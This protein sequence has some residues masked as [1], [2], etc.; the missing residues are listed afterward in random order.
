M[1]K[2]SYQKC[3]FCHE[4]YSQ[5]G[6]GRHRAA[7]ERRKRDRDADKAFERERAERGNQGMLVLLLYASLSHPISLG[8][9]SIRE[10]P[11]PHIAPLRPEPANQQR[12]FTN[13]MF[14]N[15]SFNLYAYL[16]I[17]Q[18]NH[19]WKRTPHHPHLCLYLC[20]QLRHRCPTFRW[21]ILKPS[22][23]LAV[24]N[25]QW[26]THLMSI[27]GILLPL[28]CRNHLSLGFHFKHEGTLSLQ[29]LLLM[30]GLTK[31]KPTHYST[32]PTSSS[33]SNNS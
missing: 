27:R 8:S 12:D 4:F 1:P 13:G 7:C 25:Q 14:C 21:M 18:M 26:Y 31:N 23:I 30:L 15:N 33:Q 9:R 16:V 11:S 17:N 24:V 2:S 32:L 3:N 22:I 29:H 6:I 20:L 5:R 19:R 10:Q 28:R